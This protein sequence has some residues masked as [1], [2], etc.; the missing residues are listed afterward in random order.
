MN[1]YPAI[2]ATMGSWTYY[3]VKLTMREVQEHIKF[4]HDIHDDHTLDDAIQRTINESRVKKEIVS[5]LQRQHDRFF[6]S[7]VVAA[8]E[9]NP[10][11]YP[12]SIADDEKFAIFKDD[13]RLASAFG[14]LKFDGM[15]SDNQDETVAAT[16]MRLPEAAVI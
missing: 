14:V 3:I 1:L 2:H 7:L 4:A 9:G 13:S 8:L 5:Y 6:S 16:K 10:I 15:S 12:I 11:W